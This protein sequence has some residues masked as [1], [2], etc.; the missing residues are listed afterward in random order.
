MRH[1]LIAQPDTGSIVSG[2]VGFLMALGQRL[3]SSGTPW[4]YKHL[5]LS[6]IVLSRNIFASHVIADNLY[7]HVLFI[8]SDMGFAPDTIERMIAF[9]KPIVAAACP[10]RYVAWD[11]I[12]AMAQ[13]DADQRAADERISTTELM[14]A[15]LHYNVE[16]VR[17]DGSIFTPRRQGSYITVPAIGT[18]IMLVHRDVFEIMLAQGAARSRPGYRN[19]P[20]LDTAPLCDFFSQLETPDGSMLESEDISFCWRWTDQCGGEIW[21]DIDSRILHYGLRGHAGRYWDKAHHDFPDLS[22]AQT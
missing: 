3:T 19:L 8:D 4:T 1:I 14:D 10:K 2:T 12:H 18:G 7:S 16:T 17:A 11:R 20:I 5:T 13:A 6:D 22:K 21:A 9:D 15:A